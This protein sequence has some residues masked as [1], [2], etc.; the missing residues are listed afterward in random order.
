MSHLVTIQTKVRDPDAVATA[1]ARLN[2]PAPVRGTAKLFS[3]EC[4][5]ILVQLPGWQYPAVIDTQ[6]GEVKFDN[7]AGH[8]GDQQYLDR[9]LQLYAVEKAKLEARKKGYAVSEQSLNDGSIK[10]Q[11]IEG[12]HP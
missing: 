8:W 12:A 9:F 5:G 2:L 6:T 4:V 1:C 7:F 11:I 3:G 10:L